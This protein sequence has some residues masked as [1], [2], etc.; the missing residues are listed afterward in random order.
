MSIENLS[1]K[2]DEAELDLQEVPHDIAE[3]A[4]KK[5]AT[6]NFIKPIIERL[7]EDGDLKSADELKQILAQV[8][9]TD[10]TSEELDIAKRAAG[11]YAQVLQY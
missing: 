5:E 7:R 1:G 11:K 10:T 8:M 9:H 3:L 6:V 4:V 2:G